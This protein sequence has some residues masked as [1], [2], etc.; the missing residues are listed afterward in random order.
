MSV[1]DKGM[2]K[3]M[4]GRWRPPKFG[5]CWVGKGASANIAV[6]RKVKKG[7]LEFRK[8]GEVTF[9]VRRKDGC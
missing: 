1:W 3:G 5:K 7:N 2:K 9:L 4:I 8:E 6:A